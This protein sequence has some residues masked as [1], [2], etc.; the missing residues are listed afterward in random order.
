MFRRD[1]LLGGSAA[2]LLTA[3]GG[4]DDERNS[5]RQTTL[6]ADQASA[7]QAR[8]SATTVRASEFLNAWG[9]AIRPAGAG[10]HFWVTAGGYSYQFVGDVQASPDP[11][12]R[13]LFQDALAL[14]RI[15][16]A[17]APEGEPVVDDT[18]RFVGFATG[19]AFNG[20]PLDGR[21]FPVSGQQVQ[22]DGATRTLAGSARF[23]FCTDSGV[24]SAWT[25]RDADGG[26]IVRR[27]GSAVA[28]IDHRDDGHAYFGLALKPGTWDR[29]WAADFGADPQLRAWDANWQ[30]V[31]LDGR[32]PNPFLGGRSRARPGDLVP[33]NVQVLDW[34]GVPHVFIAYARSRPDPDDASRFLAGE[35]DAL[36]RDEEGERP[37]RGGVAVYD[38]E[39]RL[40]RTIQ[41]EGRLNAPWGLAVAPADFGPLGGTLLVGNFG[42]AGRIAAFDLASGRFIDHLRRPDG[43]RVEIEGLWGLQFGNGASLGDRTA[44]YFAAGPGD[45]TRGLF[46]VLRHAP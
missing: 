3:C 40:V 32:F 21:N 33:F 9:I 35:E 10:G 22:V 20:A 38:L 27:D 41:D 45:E 8:P 13:P 39:G 29:L 17:G 14:V 30:P 6:V 34:N 18:D 4:G 2:A 37:S 23:V 12:L 44:L 5:Y 7:A 26:G 15:P 36:G 31:P 43:Q 24:I 16:G 42:G 19:V 11:A 28:V 25:E 46:G 1:F